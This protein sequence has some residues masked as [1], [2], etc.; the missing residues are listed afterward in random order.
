[1]KEYPTEL[2]WNKESFPS[3]KD[4]WLAAEAVLRREDPLLLAPRGADSPVVVKW[5]T[6]QSFSIGTPLHD[7]RPRLQALRR[8]QQ[9]RNEWPGL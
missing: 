7:T 6:S 9:W 4:A 5:E 1:M 3:A 2:E 8:L